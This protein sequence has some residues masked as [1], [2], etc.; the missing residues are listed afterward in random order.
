MTCGDGIGNAG[1]YIKKLCEKKGFS[2]MG[3][4]PVIMPENYIAMFHVP[5]RE[6]AERIIGADFKGRAFAG[7]KGRAGGLAAE[8][9]FQPGVLPALC[10]GEG[11]LRHR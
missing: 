10:L 9:H 11:L 1:A 3:V 2:L 4:S 6:S 7:R 8:H 5:D